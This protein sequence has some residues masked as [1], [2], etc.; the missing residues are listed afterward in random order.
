MLLTF[1]TLLEFYSTNLT[2]PDGIALDTIDRKIYWTDMG[3]K[4]IERADM[5]GSNRAPI[6]AVNAS[7][8]PRGIVL[9]RANRLVMP[10]FIQFINEKI[11]KLFLL[12]SIFL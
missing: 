5:D 10:I 2:L 1:S 8:N 7:E 6:L 4:K 3:T 12:L 11:E 9:Y